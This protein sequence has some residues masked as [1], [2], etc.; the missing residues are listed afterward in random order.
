M[1]FWTVKLRNYQFLV[2]M[3]N[4]IKQLNWLG[5]LDSNQD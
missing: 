4:K 3:T 1:I 5:D 2:K